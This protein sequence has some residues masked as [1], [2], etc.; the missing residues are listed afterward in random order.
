MGQTKHTPNGKQVLAFISDSLN[1]YL[2]ARVLLQNELMPQGAILSSTAIEKACKA[3]L[4]FNGNQSRGHLKKA[5]WNA[6]KNFDKGIWNSLS[7]DFLELNRKAYSLRYSD[8]LPK[9]FN[10]VIAQRE[11]LYELDTTIFSLVQ[12]FGFT[13]N[14][15]RHEAKLS[16]LIRSFDPRL[17]SDNHMLDTASKDQFVY[18]QAQRIYELRIISVGNGIETQYSSVKPAK[19]SS[20]MRPGLAYRSEGET[21]TFDLS[22]FP[23][24]SSERGLSAL[25]SSPSSEM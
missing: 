3:I 6:V 2:A 22:H 9:D 1:D 21:H 11:F 12:G 8:D 7:P 16:H 18:S 5:H 15:Q 19:L 13:Q 25:R 23:L 14:E 24:E 17:Y 10:I 4:A 20:F